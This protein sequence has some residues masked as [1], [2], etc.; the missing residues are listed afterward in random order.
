MEVNETSQGLFLNQKKYVL[1]L[2]EET[3]MSKANPAKTP[4]EGNLKHSKDEGEPILERNSFQRLIGKLI[5]PAATR[6]NII[7]V[8]NLLSQFMH[9]LQKPHV[10][11]THR[12]LRY[13]NETKGK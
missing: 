11:A 7:Y 12:V 5:Y 9:C 3:G 13:L 8:V 10:E 2:L 1:E 4:L 6:P